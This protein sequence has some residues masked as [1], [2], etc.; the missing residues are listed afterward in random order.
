MG[1]GDFIIL[2]VRG[3]LL[4]F[5]APM[6]ILYGNAALTLPNVS[7]GE[8][9]FGLV[10]MVGGCWLAWLLLRRVFFYLFKYEI[11]GVHKS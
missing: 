10:A 5:F 4:V 3:A 1:V 6:L 2:L 9:L 8:R 11:G 7:L